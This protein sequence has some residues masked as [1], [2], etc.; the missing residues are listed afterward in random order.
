MICLAYLSSATAPLSPADLEEVLGQSRRNNARDGLTGMLCHY[1]GSFLQFLE[2]DKPKVVAAFERISG[3][4]RHGGVI[5]VYRQPIATRA[6]SDWTMAVVK[7]DEI[8]AEQRA[9]CR[10]LR[11]VEFAAHASHREALEPFLES[12]RAWIR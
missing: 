10:A 5:E 12:F 8:G 6:F 3:D 4:R 9:F 11:R 2:G 1:D 7:P